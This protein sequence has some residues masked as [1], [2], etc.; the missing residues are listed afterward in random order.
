M[1]V[2]FQI[3]NLKVIFFICVENKCV[4]IVTF[5]NVS[6]MDTQG[7]IPP[8][9]DSPKKNGGNN[10]GAVIGGIVG[11][12]LAVVFVAIL[13]AFILRR[14]RNKAKSENDV[15][16]QEKK[17]SRETAKITVLKDVVVLNKLGGG[18]FSDV[19]KGEWQVNSST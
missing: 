14:R 19:Y 4:A 16:L 17:K 3:Q 1:A 9:K 10:M 5:D 12:V 18:H 11:G 2:V 15:P 7:E 6:T 8:I 13:V